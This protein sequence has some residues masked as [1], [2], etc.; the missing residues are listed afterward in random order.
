MGIPVRFRDATVGLD[1]KSHGAKDPKLIALNELKLLMFGIELA[2]ELQ[3]G[4]SRDSNS[5]TR[6]NLNFG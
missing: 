5:R 3:L 1:A 2:A 6:N 4:A